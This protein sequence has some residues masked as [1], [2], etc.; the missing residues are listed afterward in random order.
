M[1]EPGGEPTSPPLFVSIHQDAAQSRRGAMPGR[2]AML[3]QL[4]LRTEADPK[5]GDSGSD[6]SSGTT[7]NPKSLG[8]G[9]DKPKKP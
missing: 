9:K 2:P 7:K 8:L 5:D 4:I 3:D 6:T 1:N